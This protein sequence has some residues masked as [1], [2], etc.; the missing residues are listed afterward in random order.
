[1]KSYA[2]EHE[3][4]HEHIRNA[5]ML[6]GTAHPHEVEPDVLC[7][8][9]EDMKMIKGRLKEAMKLLEEPPRAHA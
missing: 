6:L 8:G 4:A 1:M 2:I 9:V 3:P 7:L 5:L